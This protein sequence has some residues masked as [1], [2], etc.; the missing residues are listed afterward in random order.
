VVLKLFHERSVDIVKD[1]L[2]HADVGVE[3]FQSQGVC[4]SLNGTIEWSVYCMFSP[5]QLIEGK[6][7]Q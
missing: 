4:R 5:P 2:F 3:N 6:T 1:G 7:D